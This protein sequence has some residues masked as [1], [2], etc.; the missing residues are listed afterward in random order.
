MRRRVMDARVARLATVRPDGHPHVVPITFALHEDMIVSAI[1]DKP[2][3]TATLQRLRNIEAHPIVSIIIDHYDDDWSLLW[4]VRADGTAR[5]VGQGTDREKAI[6]WLAA[7]YAPYLERPPRGPVIVVAVDRWT[8]WS[9]GK[10]DHS[11]V[12]AHELIEES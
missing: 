11:E 4:W 1:D 5:I 2:K 10:G 3:T 6:S 7:K 8:S 12:G 9:G